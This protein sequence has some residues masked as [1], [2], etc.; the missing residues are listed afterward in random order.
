[1]L[2]QAVELN[3]GAVW[4]G[5]A[6]DQYRMDFIKKSFDLPNEIMPFSVVCLGYSVEQNKNNDRF[7]QQKIH[8]ES[9]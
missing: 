9:Y 8:Y 4:L 3:L 1:L 5:I 2:L 7:I 6:P